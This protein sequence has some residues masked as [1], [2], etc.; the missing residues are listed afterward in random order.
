MEMTMRRE[1]FEVPNISCAHCVATIERVVGEI[2]GVA[3]VAASADSKL[4]EVEYKPPATRE[5]IV[6]VLTEWDYPPL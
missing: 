1:Q 4:V 3:S 2:E 5:A 6:A